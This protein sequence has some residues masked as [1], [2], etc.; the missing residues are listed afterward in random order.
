MRTL[1]RTTF[2]FFVGSLLFCQCQPDQENTAISGKELVIG[3][4]PPENAD[5]N[6]DGMEAI[7]DY[8][9]Q[10]L[11][12]EVEHLQVSNSAA[13]IEAMRADKIDVGSGGTFSYLVAA[14]KA[15]AEALVTTATPN[16]KPNYYRS[17]LITYPSSGIKY[18]SGRA[19]I[20][21]SKRSYSRPTWI[22]P[23]MLPKS[24]KC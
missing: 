16:G 6:F 18:L 8:F 22:C 9:S 15:G 3:M 13:M 7:T 5:R 20:Q 14:E 21:P 19:L 12:I 10:K 2:L 4:T 1:A 17:C 11:G 24:G 23:E